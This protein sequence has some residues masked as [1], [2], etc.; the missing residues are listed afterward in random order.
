VAVLTALYRFWRDDELLYVGIT[1][2]PSRRFHQ[3]ASSQPWWHLANRITIETHPTREDALVAEREAIIRE[4]PVHN[5]V[6]TGRQRP[7]APSIVR[8][9]GCGTIINAG[10]GYLEVDQ[11]LARAFA[12]GLSDVGARWLGWHR[13]CDPE[14]D[15]QRYF[16]NAERLL[17]F[18]DLM[19]WDQHLSAKRWVVESTDWEAVAYFTLLEQASP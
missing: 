6:H 8:C 16:V 3:H 5:I 9:H 4:K 17:T 1:L 11:S 14:P 18:D 13:R 7:D 2:N 10:D 15:G 12:S 19:R